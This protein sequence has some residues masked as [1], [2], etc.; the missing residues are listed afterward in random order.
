MLTV[1]TK[2]TNSDADGIRVT[3]PQPGV[4]HHHCRF[5]LLPLEIPA[6]DARSPLFLPQTFRNQAAAATAEL[7]RGRS[8][9]EGP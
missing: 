1:S 4:H 3:P 6:G 9:G 5:F 8:L 2:T 7:C